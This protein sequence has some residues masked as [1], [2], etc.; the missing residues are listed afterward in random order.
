[1]TSERSS[2][3][4][5]TTTNPEV[6]SLDTRVLV[7][8]T[9]VGEKVWDAYYADARVGMGDPSS[10]DSLFRVMRDDE[11]Y[12]PMTLKTVM[13]IFGGALRDNPDALPIEPEMKLISDEN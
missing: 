5:E 7:R 11:G 13:Q 6:V 9:E 12:T 8:I 2:R 1:M 10:H 4:I 3:S